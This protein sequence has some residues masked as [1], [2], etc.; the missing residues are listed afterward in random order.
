MVSV[1]RGTYGQVNGGHDDPSLP[2][3]G[4][5]DSDHLT[6]RILFDSG[7]A[8]GLYFILKTTDSVLI[9]EAIQMLT[10]D[11]IGREYTITTR[12]TIGNP[13]KFE[14]EPWYAVALWDS[15]LNGFSDTETGDSDAG[16]LTAWFH[17]DAE[18]VDAF[19][20]N[21]A[22]R[23]AFAAEYP[24]GSWIGVWEDSNG[25]VRVETSEN[26]PIDVASDSDETEGE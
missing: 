23:E 9:R 3:S 19:T 14:G 26:E 24:A 20:S 7:I 21:A 11:E 6:R 17:V 16:D 2:G 4:V 10:R 12:G 25:F 18:L 22:E 15:V 13:G 1:A 8:F 5:R